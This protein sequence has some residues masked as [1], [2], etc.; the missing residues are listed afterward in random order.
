MFD[1]DIKS[2]IQLCE[3][4]IIFYGIR[5]IGMDT[6]DG[7]CMNKEFKPKNIKKVK[8]PP[9]LKVE[10]NEIDY[11]ELSKR[12]YGNLLLEFSKK[13]IEELPEKNLTNFY[14]NIRTL[15]VG[16]KK[17]E[18]ERN[19]NTTTVGTYETKKNQVKFTN[20]EKK[21]VVFHELFH[22]AS[23]KY[24][25]GITYSGFSQSK[26]LSG[27]KIGNGLNEGYTETMSERYFGRNYSVS[28]GYRYAT[29]VVAR[30]EE[31]V[32]RERMEELYLN[33][34]L[35]GLINELKKYNS[36]ENIMKFIAST[37]FLLDRFSLKKFIF[38]EKGKIKKSLRNVNK[39]LAE[40]YANFIKEQLD[41]GKISY[42]K[43]NFNVSLFMGRLDRYVDAS[44]HIFTVMKDEEIEKIVENTFGDIDLLISPEVKKNKVKKIA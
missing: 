13:I 3:P 36:E 20:E 5:N 34:D 23:S 28:S 19:S 8:L 41:E 33:A 1:I 11:D 4:F 14:N 27:L 42:D 16:L 25:N 7:I 30:V 35:L 39:F 26:F 2:L 22:M 29:F 38:R 24:Q 18:K 12:Q 40:S 31:I 17:E 43:A 15:K 44:D 32:G 9:E 21:Q 6:I 10:A 37:D